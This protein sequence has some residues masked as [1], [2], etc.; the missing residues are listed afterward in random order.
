MKTLDKTWCRTWCQRALYLVILVGLLVALAYE[1]ALCIIKYVEEPTYYE[2]HIERQSD[3][4]FPDITLCPYFDNVVCLDPDV[5]RILR[6]KEWE[7]LECGLRGK[8]SEGWH[9]QHSCNFLKGIKNLNDPSKY[10]PRGFEKNHPTDW[11]KTYKKGE[12]P[13][14]AKERS[15]KYFQNESIFSLC[16]VAKP[17]ITH[18]DFIVSNYTLAEF[19]SMINVTTKEGDNL[20]VWNAS[21]NGLMNNTLI[22]IKTHWV[23]GYGTCQTLK[24]KEALR[25]K[26]ISVVEIKKKLNT[27][28]DMHIM[29][30]LHKRNTFYRKDTRKEIYFQCYPLKYYIDYDVKK[31][32]A[33]K[34]GTKNCRDYNFDQECIERRFKEDI[35][36]V[37]T[38]NCSVPTNTSN[39]PIC[40]ILED[41]KLAQNLTENIVNRQIHDCDNICS[42]MPLTFVGTGSGKEGASGTLQLLFQPMVS[43]SVEKDLY[44]LGSLGAEIGGY[45]GV[46]V[47]YSILSFVEF[48][49]SLMK[50]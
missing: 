20:V 3:T 45:V 31:E 39:I 4:K 28:D 21:Q 37:T 26:E 10:F 40:R 14:C 19:I 8:L 9:R 42:T 13:P 18:D 15:E 48:L 7:Y 46:M 16:Q 12:L 34:H 43:A 33:Y 47:G 6:S 25:Q 24:F 35:P 50:K 2:T 23:P 29:T 22:K 5:K 32:K 44:S 38:N 41:M 30:A 27:P 11:T 1:V 36:R 17:E 49:F